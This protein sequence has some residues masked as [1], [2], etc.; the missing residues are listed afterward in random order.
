[1]TAIGYPITVIAQRKQAIHQMITMYPMSHKVTKMQLLEL[2]KTWGTLKSFDFGKHKRCPLLNNAYL[3][4]FLE[5]PKLEN[6]PSTIQINNRNIEINIQGQLKQPRCAYCKS[7]EHTIDEC[8]TKPDRNPNPN[9]HP[10]LP[11]F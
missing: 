5:D 10:F 6:I 8:I 7:T 2:T 3:H 4:L 1:M 9:K 11:K